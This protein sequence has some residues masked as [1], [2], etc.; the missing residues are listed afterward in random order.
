MARREEK[1]L[2]EVLG[3]MGLAFEVMK[4][5]V[6]AILQ[7]GG[8]I[9]HLRRLLKEPELMSQI[10]DLIVAHGNL[11]KLPWQMLTVKLLPGRTFGEMLAAGHYGW[12]NPDITEANFPL[13][14]PV[15]AEKPASCGPYRT[16]A[17]AEN[18]QEV[19]LVHLNK[20]VNTSE[21][22]AHLDELGLAP[23]GIGELL[24]VGEQ[25]PDLQK[26]F[27]IIALG[28][29]WV[30][31]HGDRCVPYLHYWYGKREL[32][33]RWDEYEWDEFCRFLVVRK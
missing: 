21:A 6:H 13:S 7:K 24:A 10:V 27:P 33:L 17:R 11:D 26:N 30:N 4:V 22:L 12:S 16:A 3:N 2:K 18:D 25:H 20:V 14:T 32:Y 29:S 1:N 9:N 23:A 28:S 8:E 31:P 15:R 5:L 19:F